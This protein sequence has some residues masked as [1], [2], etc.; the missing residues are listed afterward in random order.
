MTD[1]PI[2]GLISCVQA[3]T[4]LK[5]HEAPLRAARA[6]YMFLECRVLLQK[7]YNC[8]SFQQNVHKEQMLGTC[9]AAAMQGGHQASAF[10]SET[11]TTPGHSPLEPSR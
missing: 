5:P 11:Y 9:L 4:S 8:S 2:N 7:P 10:R 6:I 1:A 3:L